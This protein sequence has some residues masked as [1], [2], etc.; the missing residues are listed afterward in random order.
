MPSPSV[1]ETSRLTLRPP[2]TG[3]RDAWVRLHRD[4]RT[5]WHAP[6]AMS[7]TDD[8]AANFLDRT[9]AHWD[10]HGF[11]FWVAEDR[12]SGDVVGVCGLKVIEDVFLNLYYRLTNDSLGRGLGREMSRASVAHAVEWLPR[13]PVRALVK[14]VNTPSVATA[15]ATG[16]ERAGTRVLHDDLPDEPPS[17][18]FEAPTIEAATSFDAATHDEVLDLWVRTNEAGG[19]VGF[20][21]GAPRARVEAAL[22]SSE[23]R[24]AE[25]SRVAVVQR[26]AADGALLGL[27]FL[28]DA[29]GRLQAHERWVYTVMTE[30]ERRGQ[31]LGR[32]LMAGT[33]RVAREAGVEIL[34][35]G[36]RSGMGTTAF[37]GACGYRESGRILGGIRV[38]EGD[39]RDNIT[40]TRRLDGRTLTPDPRS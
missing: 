29:G 2:T 11:G 27:A 37:Y 1:V 35:L 34:T 3:D 39:D 30:P 20:L 15:L 28:A 14:E 25:G 7:R 24:M 16:L 12:G 23:E 17:T 18:V 4:P 22:N 9:L 8:D 19:A 26:S 31:N 32:L 13:L 40:M 38:G 6:H 36:V 5:Y 10:E 33:H 21:P